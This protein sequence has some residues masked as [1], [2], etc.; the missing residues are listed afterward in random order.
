MLTSI[1]FPS[2]AK[3]GRRRKELWLG[4]SYLRAQP[5]SRAQEGLRVGVL[6]GDYGHFSIQ[7]FL[8][9]KA[10]GWEGTAQGWPECYRS[11]SPVAD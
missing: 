1:Q 7:H 9:E 2:A 11:S 3:A 8:W 5:L 4:G 6:H 10:V